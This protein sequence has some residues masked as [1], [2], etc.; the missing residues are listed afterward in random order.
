MFFE[1]EIETAGRDRIEALQLKRL[2]E[3]VR[4]VYEHVPM[5]RGRL[6]EAGIG[7][8]GIRS[9]DDLRRIP[10]TVKD[11]LRQNYPFGMFATP[12]RD[13]VRIHASSGTTGKPTVVGYT[14]E[15]LS[16]WST[17]MARLITATGVGPDDIAQVAF[18]YGLFTGAFGLHYAL[19]KVGCAVVPISAGNTE[20]QLMLMQDFGVT[21]LISTPSYAQYIA[22]TAQKMGLV[23]GRDLKLRV[24]L[25]GGEACSDAMRLD[26]ERRLGMLATQNYGL[27]EVIGPGISGECECQSGL[28]FNE[29]HFIPEVIDPDTGRVLPPGEKGELVLTALTKQALPIL[30]YRTKDLTRLIPEPCACGRTHMRMEKVMGRIDDML[31]IRGVNVFPSQIEEVLASVEE[32]GPNYEIVVTR[33]GYLDHMLVKVELNDSSLLERFSHLEGLENR[34]RQRIRTVLGLDVSVRL[35][36]HQSLKRFEGKA[37]RV[38]DLRKL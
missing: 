22:E 5:Y 35:V 31:I 1:P 9:L 32:V 21:V 12:M 19:E 37:R 17:C 6:D 27:S 11:D 25:F 33:E 13:V 7:P 24:G 23:P 3:T 4:R 29:D 28:H 15:D 8:D 14:K 18:G 38:T 2:R 20:K 26:I 10:F 34:I 36:E 30:R 16:T